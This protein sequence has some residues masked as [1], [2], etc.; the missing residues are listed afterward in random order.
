M[1]SSVEVIRGQQGARGGFTE[2]K[3]TFQEDGSDQ[4]KEAEH[5]SED[6]C[7]HPERAGSRAVVRKEEEDGINL[8]T[9]EKVESA[10]LVTQWLQEVWQKDESKT[11]PGSLVS[12]FQLF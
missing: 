9:T 4:N 11:I 7:S 2:V 1:L 5:G 6:G 10:D 12:A 3:C 8:R